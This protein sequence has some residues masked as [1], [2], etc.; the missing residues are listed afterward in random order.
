MIKKLFLIQSLL[1]GTL[2][3]FAQTPQ[4]ESTACITHG[5]HES[6]RQQY[7]GIPSE[8]EFE[9]RLQ[10]IMAYSPEPKESREVL[11][12][13]VVVH[14]IPIIAKLDSR[15]C[16]VHIHRLLDMGSVFV[17][18]SPYTPYRTY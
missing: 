5:F 13:P 7:P 12:V 9:R 16:R 6:L 15:E 2:I 8:E 3:M 18:C 17:V 10:E 4:E 11:R 14:I 1:L